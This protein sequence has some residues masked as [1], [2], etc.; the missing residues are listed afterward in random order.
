MIQKMSLDEFAKKKFETKDEKEKEKEESKA[1]LDGTNTGGVKKK[2][3]FAAS[4]SY[5]S[6]SGN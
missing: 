4:K 1:V 2:T 3:E 5:T 6:F